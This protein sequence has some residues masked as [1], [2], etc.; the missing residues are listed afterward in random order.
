MEVYCKA[1]TPPVGGDSM[2]KDNASDRKIY[3]PSASVD[4][5]KAASVWSTYAAD[6]VGY[7]FE[8]NAIVE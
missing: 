8:N 4:A 2:F 1:T 6:I 3:V 7:D 5:Y